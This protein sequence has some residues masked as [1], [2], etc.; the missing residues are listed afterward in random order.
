HGWG[1]LLVVTSLTFGMSVTA[2]GMSHVSALH[3]G[4][5]VIVSRQPVVLAVPFQS[6]VAILPVLLNGISSPREL[7]SWEDTIRQ[8]KSPDKS[9]ILKPYAKKIR[10]LSIENSFI[11]LGKRIVNSVPWIGDSESITLQNGAN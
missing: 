8:L 6:H 10:A 7:D 4:K 5:L 9:N 1:A 11:A 3:S 2:F